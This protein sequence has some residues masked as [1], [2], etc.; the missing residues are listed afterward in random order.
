MIYM[1]TIWQDRLPAE[2]GTIIGT[3]YNP[4]IADLFLYCNES[5]TFTTGFRKPIE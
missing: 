3:N 5:H 1:C 4:F 2:N